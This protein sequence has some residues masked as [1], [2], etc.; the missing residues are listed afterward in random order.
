MAK[1]NPSNERERGIARPAALA[2]TS[3]IEMAKEG[4]THFEQ[5]A[6]IGGREI[7]FVLLYSSALLARL[8]SNSIDGKLIGFENTELYNQRA[9]TDLM[10]DAGKT[11]RDV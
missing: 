3:I 7:I 10:T 1:I 4:S 6:K 9:V 8:D 2:V 5:N 11:R